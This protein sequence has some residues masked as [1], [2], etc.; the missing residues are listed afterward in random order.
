MAVWDQSL[1]APCGTSSSRLSVLVGV[2]FCLNPPPTRLNQDNHRL[3]DLPS[4]VTP[5]VHAQL[6]WCR[7]IN[8]LPIAYALR[9]RLRV[10]THPG[11]TSLA[12]ET[13]GFRRAGFSPALSLLMSAS[14]LPSGPP[15]LPVRLL[16][17]GNAPLPT[18][19]SRLWPRSFGI[20]LEPR[21]IFGA[22][23]LDQ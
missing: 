20:V 19:D 18:K 15:L 2:R 22:G 1:P 8:L 7:N 6:R 4:C 21:Y 17:Q 12:Q 3:A 9:P 16:P 5:S 11:W 23:P 10:S 13:L 14:A